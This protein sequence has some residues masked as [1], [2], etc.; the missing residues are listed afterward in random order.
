LQFGEVT[1]FRGGMLSLHEVYLRAL[2]VSNEP[3]AI[4]LG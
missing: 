3:L 1:D 2:N 4:T